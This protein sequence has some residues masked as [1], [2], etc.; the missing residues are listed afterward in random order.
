MRITKHGHS[1]LSVTEGDVT[2]LLDPGSFSPGFEELTGVDSVLVTHTHADHVDAP[3]VA[4]LLERN[5]AARVFAEAAAADVL[6]EA[7]VEVTTVSPGE[8]FDVAGLPVRTFGGHHAVIHDD[9]PRFGNVGFLVGGRLFHPGD[10][11]EVPETDVEILAVPAMA[12]WMAMKEAIDFER[13]VAPRVAVPIHDA[14]LAVKGLYY[15]RLA[16]MG[17]AGL[18][19]EDLDDGRTLEL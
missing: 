5:P 9:L 19:F 18:R 17:P 14:L 11:L 7:G 16:A 10:S 13:A 2:V 12:P 4:A 8:S 1:C 6:R 15:E 3:R